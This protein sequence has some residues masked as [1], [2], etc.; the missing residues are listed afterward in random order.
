MSDRTISQVLGQHWKSGRSNPGVVV[1]ELCFSLA[2][3]C[4]DSNREPFPRR[5]CA[6]ALSLQR[7]KPGASLKWVVWVL[8]AS[9]MYFPQSL[10]PAGQV[11]E[12]KPMAKQA[13]GETRGSI[14]SQLVLGLSFKGKKLFYFYSVRTSLA[15]YWLWRRCIAVVKPGFAWIWEEGW[16]PL[17]PT[18]GA[19]VSYPQPEVGFEVL[20]THRNLICQVLAVSPAQL[21]YH[22]EG[23]CP[24]G[25]SLGAGARTG[26]ESTN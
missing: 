22:Y 23:V 20:S 2:P 24:Q 1:A 26:I 19:M 4:S 15:L 10:G 17:L 11:L 12:S 21:C 6:Q 14:P 5:V 3:F 18:L 16:K 25:L 7:E 9:C 8:I 13:L